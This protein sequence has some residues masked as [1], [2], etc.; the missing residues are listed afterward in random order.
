MPHRVFFL[1]AP[2]WLRLP[3]VFLAAMRTKLNAA[4]SHKR[5]YGATDG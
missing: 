4:A 1:L 2:E 5:S 3:L